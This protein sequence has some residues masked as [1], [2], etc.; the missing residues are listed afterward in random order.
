MKSTFT[1]AKT[2]KDTGWHSTAHP[3]KPCWPTNALSK[4]NIGQKISMT[5]ELQR[6]MR[7]PHRKKIIQKRVPWQKTQGNSN[8]AR[9]TTRT[10]Y[11]IPITWWMKCIHTMC[12]YKLSTLVEHQG[13]QYCRTS[14]QSHALDYTAHS[15]IPRPTPFQDAPTPTPVTAAAISC[16][17]SRAYLNYQSKQR[18][19]APFKDHLHPKWRKNAPFLDHHHPHSTKSLKTNI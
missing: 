17:S 14:D 16:T 18:K 8:A 10:G 1:K 9:V 7:P 12:C 2:S 4:R 13:R 19:T 5:C 11:V 15:P 6:S 3:F